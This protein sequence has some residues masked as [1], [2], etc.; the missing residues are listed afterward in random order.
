ME[1]ISISILIAVIGVV[2]SIITFVAG[3]Q[4]AAKNQGLQDGQILT[5]LGYLKSNT[6][7]IKKRLDEEDHRHIETIQKLAELDSSLK[8]AHKR[9]DGL[10]K[11]YGV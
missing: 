6:D 5:E 11:R 9:L 7:E 4:T 1:N 2:L 10:E 3:R 8:S